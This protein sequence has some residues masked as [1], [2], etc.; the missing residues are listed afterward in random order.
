MNFIYYNLTLLVSAIPAVFLFNIGV[1][2]CLAPYLFFQGKYSPPKVLS[3]VTDLITGAFQIYFWGL[4]SAYCVSVTYKYTTRA[5]VT[6]DW[7][8]FLVGFFYSTSIILSLN[9]K[10]QSGDQNKI[11]KILSKT[12]KNSAYYYV[13]AWIAF[14][15]F[16]F[17]PSFITPVYGWATDVL[18]LTR[19]IN[20]TQWSENDRECEKRYFS[21]KKKAEIIWDFFGKIGQPG[22]AQPDTSLS[23]LKVLL[24]QAI[25]E[26]DLVSDEFLIKMYPDYPRQYKKFRQSLQGLSEFLKTKEDQTIVLAF[27]Q[28]NQ[29]C[30]WVN[31]NYKQ[32]RLIE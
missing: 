10:E 11:R 30:E 9:S 12:Q 1:V 6:L 7:I 16:S 23:D 2:A 5:D 24:A 17:R 22:V 8:Y 3:I 31:A 4:W 18:G 21:A 25:S 15:L 28:Y 13:I 20:L 27:R 29:Y 19:Y 26:A 32:F 14:L